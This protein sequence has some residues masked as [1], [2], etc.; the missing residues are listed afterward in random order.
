MSRCPM[1]KCAQCE[2][3]HQGAYKTKRRKKVD[4]ITVCSSTPTEKGKMT[5]AKFSKTEKELKFA[6]DA[7]HTEK[8][9]VLTRSQ[10]QQGP[11]SMTNP[12]W[13]ED[14]ICL[15][16]EFLREEQLKD[17]ARVDALCWI[18]NSQRLE[19]DE[20]LST[21]IDQKFLWASFDCLV[22]PR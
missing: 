9:R 11:K 1:L 10:R 5:R 4:V 12:S 17:L 20:I 8:A 15:N 7:V 6:Q 22:C 16:R 13:M 14:G 19:R 18:K 21:V 3:R 2:T